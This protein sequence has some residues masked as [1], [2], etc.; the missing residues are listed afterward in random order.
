MEAISSCYIK[1]Y[2]LR[3]QN[4]PT[5]INKYHLTNEVLLY[6]DFYSYVVRHAEISIYAFDDFIRHPFDFIQ[7]IES[8]LSYPDLIKSTVGDINQGL[9]QAKQLEKRKNPLGS[10]LPNKKRT[11]QKNHCMSILNIF[12]K[13]LNVYSFIIVF[14]KEEKF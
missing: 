12:L 8:M 13:C 2:A 9:E 1:Y 5:E 14:I 7:A 4:V 3:N 6:K 10:S 11:Q